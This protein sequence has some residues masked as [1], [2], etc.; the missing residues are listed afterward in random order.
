MKVKYNATIDAA[1]IELVPVAPGGV[2][3][4][5][6]CSPQGVDGQIHLDFDVE[7][8]LVGLEVLDASRLL[9]DS[10]LAEATPTP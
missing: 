4:T 1:Y 6:P 3:R 5:Y 7:G 9:P 2:H 10:V 8:Q